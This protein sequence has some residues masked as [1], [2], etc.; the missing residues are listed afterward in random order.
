MKKALINISN[1][2]SSGWSED[3]RAG[4]DKIVDIP[5]PP[6]SPESDFHEVKLLAQEITD[7]VAQISNAE[8]GIYIMIQG[9]YSL[10]YAVF[11]MLKELKKYK[12]VVPTTARV[13][14]E[15]ARPDGT[16]EK[17]SVFRF[18]RWRVIDL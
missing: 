16:V 2:P 3:Q 10:S 18:I 12:F 8:E 14:E 6:V 1:H 7:K 9:E 4:W 5:F 11:S 17:V 13:V 15:K